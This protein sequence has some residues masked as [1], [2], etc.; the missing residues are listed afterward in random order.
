MRR[1]TYTQSFK[2]RK[3]RQEALE[4][5]RT[6]RAAIDPET[7]AIARAAI[8]AQQEPEA[9]DET[10]SPESAEAAPG[11]VP[12]DRR[13]NLSIIMKYLEMKKD[14]KSLLQAIRDLMLRA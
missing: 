5:L 1:V 4:A 11:F 14:N 2:K 10:Q 9:P 13:K 12:V 8:E 7:L 3:I 6:A